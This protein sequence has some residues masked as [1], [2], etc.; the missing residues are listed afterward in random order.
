[1]CVSTQSGHSHSLNSRTLGFVAS[2][3]GYL[4]SECLSTRPL[5]SCRRRLLSPEVSIFMDG[6][7]RYAFSVSFSNVQNLLN[8]SKIRNQFFESYVC[9]ISVINRRSGRSAQKMNQ[10]LK[11]RTENPSMLTV[12]IATINLVDTVGNKSDHKQVDFKFILSQY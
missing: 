6:A 11:I 12:A 3:S 7:L 4:S 10:E 1:M 5:R 9:K 2:A 8:R